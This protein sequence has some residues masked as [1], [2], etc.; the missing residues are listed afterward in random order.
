[1]SADA[2]TESLLAHEE[3]AE[4]PAKAGTGGPAP[5]VSEGPAV[6]A[7]ARDRLDHSLQVPTLSNQGC[8]PRF[9]NF[10]RGLTS[11]SCPCLLLP[12][13]CICL[14]TAHAV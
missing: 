2:E 13:C 12:A 11:D 6:L 1:M 14:A 5:V 10:L 8:G 4:S 7:T 9:V 3:L